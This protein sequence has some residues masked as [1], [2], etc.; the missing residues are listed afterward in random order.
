V[1]QAFLEGHRERL[2]E[3]GSHVPE[4]YLAVSLT[5]SAPAGLS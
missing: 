3:L 4:A 5:R 2:C 1:W